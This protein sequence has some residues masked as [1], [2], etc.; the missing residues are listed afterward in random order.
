VCYRIDRPHVPAEDIGVAY[1]DP[2]LGIEWP[3]PGSVVS[4][5]DASAG[6]W[7]QVLRMVWQGHRG[8]DSQTIHGRSPLW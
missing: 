5:R 8:A 3:L 7:E 4:P 2:D 1:D 6:S